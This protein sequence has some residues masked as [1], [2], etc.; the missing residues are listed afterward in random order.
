MWKSKNLSNDRFP[1]WTKFEFW[2]V[3]S[4]QNEQIYSSGSS[5]GNRVKR[6]LW[7]RQAKGAKGELKT[8]SQQFPPLSISL[9]SQHF[10]SSSYHCPIPKGFWQA[11]M[12]WATR[13]HSV[14][15][16]VRYWSSSVE[17]ATVLGLGTLFLL[18]VLLFSW[19]V[20]SHSCATLQELLPDQWWIQI[21]S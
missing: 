21:F 14:A 8:W 15:V 17:V 12:S 19:R 16:L 13:N 5:V 4:N 3:D 18:I 1:I 6:K 11:N 2:Y 10:L 7:S 20:R 9:L